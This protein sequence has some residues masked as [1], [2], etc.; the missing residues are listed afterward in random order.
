MYL[1]GVLGVI[2][3][4]MFRMVNVDSAENG[5]ID[6]GRLVPFLLRI[7]VILVSIKIGYHFS[8]GF[9]I[10]CSRIRSILYLID[11]LR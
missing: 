10:L 11:S 4:E 7:D 2:E 1:M 8:Y 5:A 9:R 3:S 6:E